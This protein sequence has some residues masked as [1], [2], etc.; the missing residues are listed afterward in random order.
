M[1]WKNYK[2]IIPAILGLIPILSSN[3]GYPIPLSVSTDII[4]IAIFFVGLMAKDFDK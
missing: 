4:G 1:F 3:L 2:T